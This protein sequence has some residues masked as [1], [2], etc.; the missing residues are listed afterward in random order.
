MKKQAL[1]RG[2]WASL[3]MIAMLTLSACGGQ[4]STQSSNQGAPEPASA[5]SA[6]A[7]PSETKKPSGKVVVYTAGPAGLAD[8]ILE[9]F[10]AK[11][12]LTV[13]QFQGTTGKVLARL[14]A[15]KSNPVA[16][17]VVLASWPSGMSMKQEGW[18]Q[19]YTEAVHADRLYDGWVDE[20]R[21]LFGYSASA[22]GITYNTKLVDNPPSDWS[23]LT[24]AQWTGAVNIPDP[25][26]SGSA[27]DFV[28]GYLNQYGESGW[29]LFDALKQN[30]VTMAG[31]NQEALDPVVTGAK[32]VVMAGVDYMAYS[33]KAKGEPVDIVY[34]A[35]GTV[36][37]PRP[38]MILKDAPNLDNAKLFIDYLLSDEAQA[39]VANA[40]LLP[41]RTD[42]PA[43][44]DRTQVEE[45]KLLQYDWN[46]MSENGDDITTQFMNVFK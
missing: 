13:E 39:L 29:S 28:S 40:Y 45:I 33:A 26:L 24:D 32:S 38:A 5:Q 8:K 2:K 7:P 22:L 21:H 11:T 6:E 42:V 3:L 4:A 44:E 12:G 37:N 15:E 9:G 34:P 14:E 23:D 25:S 31:A 18:T 30:G 19:A 10:Q 1:M 27:L 17:I 43:K 41:G 36:I 20:D 16:D 35:S 46:W